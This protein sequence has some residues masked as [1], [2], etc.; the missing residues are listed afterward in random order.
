MFFLAQF[1]L[2][3]IDDWTTTLLLLGR[4][5]EP[6]TSNMDLLSRTSTWTRITSGIK[7]LCYN[8]G[9]LY[10]KW[11]FQFHFHICSIILKSRC[12]LECLPYSLCW[13]E[14]EALPWWRSWKIDYH[15][16]SQGSLNPFDRQAS[17][18]KEALIGKEPR[19][20]IPLCFVCSIF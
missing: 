19:I 10:S 11:I 20:S 2:G 8:K 6:P 7:G 1:F 18:V 4:M 9:L 15:N 16:S 5:W 12:V 17:D 3:C 13:Q 14:I